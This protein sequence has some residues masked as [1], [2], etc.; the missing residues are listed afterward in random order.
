M[1]QLSMLRDQVT[2]WQ[3][4]SR[5]AQDALTL[6]EMATEEED[7]SLLEELTTE[8]EAI[9]KQLGRLEFQLA[10]SGKHDKDDGL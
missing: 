7:T 5:R 10:F 2:T 6:V 3:N 4:L 8:T 9:E 1:Q